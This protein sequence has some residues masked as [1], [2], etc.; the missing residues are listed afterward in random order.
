MSD[1]LSQE[2]QRVQLELA[3][4][5]VPAFLACLGIGTLTAI[6]QGTVP[7]ETGIWTLA[8]P[9]F[10]EPLLHLSTIP[11]DLLEVFGTSDELVALQTVR[12]EQFGV[13]VAEMVNRLHAVLAQVADPDW[14][15]RCRWL[16][17]SVPAPHA[18]EPPTPDEGG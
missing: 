11:T 10:R 6:A 17:E 8:V 2:H 9:R 12:P 4:H 7:P 14:G 16:L 18:G 15:M 1:E 13:V 5:D 3:V